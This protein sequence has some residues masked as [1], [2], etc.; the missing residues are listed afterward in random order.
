MLVS[1]RNPGQPARDSCCHTADHRQDLQ[2]IQDVPCSPAR[3]RPILLVSVIMTSIA[4]KTWGFSPLS[5]RFSKHIPSTSASRY[6]CSRNSGAM[7]SRYRT[8]FP[9]LSY[10]IACPM[11]LMLST[12][13]KQHL[14][15]RNGRIVGNTLQNATF[16]RV[17]RNV[18]GFIMKPVHLKY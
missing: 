17:Y 9:G 10:W 13:D 4:A 3:I 11:E 1:A 12:G 6:K 5:A 16:K 18:S 8:I 14:S 7:K 15:K 2:H